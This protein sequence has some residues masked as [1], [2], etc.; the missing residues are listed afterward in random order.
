[1]VLKIAA[2]ILVKDNLILIAKRKS[3]DR[4]APG[5]WEF[6]GGKIEAGET[7]EECVK[8]ELKEE[9]GIDVSVNGLFAQ[10][11]H[12]YEGFG[13]IQLLAYWTEWTGDRMIPAVHDQVRFASRHELDQ[14]DFAPADIPI[15]EKLIGTN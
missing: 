10:N 5:K 7:P 12:C 2:A 3:T 14:Y 13:T 8:R 1:M 9:L 15:V 6:P 4:V 11:T